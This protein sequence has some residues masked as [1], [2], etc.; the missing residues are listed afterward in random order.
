M[1]NIFV[2]G[3]RILITAWCAFVLFGMVWIL[4]KPDSKAAPS[5]TPTPS[6]QSTIVIDSGYGNR[7]EVRQTGNIDSN[8]I[9]IN[10]VVYPGKTF[11]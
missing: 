11:K 10:G 8:Y 7:I 9:K 4:F 3:W 1:K 5:V 2:N 6:Q